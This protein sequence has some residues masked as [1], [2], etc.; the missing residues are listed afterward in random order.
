[1]LWTR[2]WLCTWVG[3]LPVKDQCVVFCNLRPLCALT[4]MQT[5][6]SLGCALDTAFAS[7]A[8]MPQ[9]TTL[10]QTPAAAGPGMAAGWVNGPPTCV[11][12]TPGP[13]LVPGFGGT[14]PPDWAAAWSRAPQ[15]FGPDGRALPG[16][17]AIPP[18]DFAGT[19]TDPNTGTTYATY[20]Q[21]MPLPIIPRGGDMDYK[22]AVRSTAGT[23][24]LALEAMTGNSALTTRPCPQEMPRD[25]AEALE[26]AKVPT[27]LLQQAVN[28][29]VAASAAR[30]TYFVNREVAKPLP[31]VHWE[32]YI[33]TT[34]V[35]RERAD[36]QTVQD[37]DGGGTALLPDRPQAPDLTLVVPMAKDP[38]GLG[39]PLAPSRRLLAHDKTTQPGRPVRDDV[40]DGRARLSTVDDRLGSARLP[41]TIRASAGRTTP[42]DS[43][44]HG[45]VPTTLLAPQNDRDS[46]R[47]AFMG[48]MAA[49]AT[50]QHL[51]P[52][53]HSAQPPQAHSDGVKGARAGL[54]G[55]LPVS[56]LA[57][58]SGS[59]SS[60]GGVAMPMA[61]QGGAGRRGDPMGG[62]PLPAR[63]S[64]QQAHQSTAGG[65][66]LTR[67]A[68][69]THFHTA[70]RDSSGP[71]LRVAPP[72]VV[73]APSLPA[74]VSEGVAGGRRTSGPSQPLPVRTPGLAGA[75]AATH[76][77]SAPPGLPAADAAGPGRRGQA[78]LQGA[79][80]VTHDL[81]A[82]QQPGGS[83][84]P[85]TAASAEGVRAT[86]EGPVGGARP[87]A[88]GSSAFASTATQSNVALQ[89][90]LPSS[91][92]AKLRQVEGPAGGA[93]AIATGA[94]A[95]GALGAMGAVGAGG[96]GS[97]LQLP[98]ASDR[99]GPR[100]SGE[101]PAGG[102]RPLGTA[103]SLNGGGENSGLQLTPA[104]DRA[105]PRTSGEG[106]AGGARPLAT[107]S[108]AAE[109]A[110]IGRP[111]FT[112]TASAL[113]AAQS[114]AFSA[115]RKV[116]RP[117][118]PAGGARP[119]ASG[120]GAMEH[121]GPSAGGGGG[122][123]AAG[124]LAAAPSP[125][126]R[127]LATWNEGPVGGARGPTLSAPGWTTNPSMAAP[128]PGPA[129]VPGSRVRALEGPAGGAR[130]ISTGATL[131]MP[132]G[133]AADTSTAATESGPRT[134]FR[135]GAVTA[136]PRGPGPAVLPR[137]VAA[138]AAS[139]RLPT[140]PMMD[141][142]TRGKN[143]LGNPAEPVRTPFLLGSETAGAPPSAFPTTPAADPATKWGSQAGM[144]H[145]LPTT[146]LPGGLP[147]ALAQTGMGMGAPT[148]FQGARAAREPQ[149]P[150]GTRVSA[151][152]AAQQVH[153]DSSLAPGASQSSRSV[154]QLGHADLPNATRVQYGVHGVPITAPS[155]PAAVPSRDGV[156]GG[157]GLG[158]RAPRVAQ[159]Q[160]HSQTQ[161]EA[162]LGPQDALGVRAARH[163]M[164]PG[165]ATRASGVHLAQS[166][167]VSGTGVGPAVAAD[168]V[169]AA[170]RYL[171]PGATT[172]AP[173][174]SLSADGGTATT[175]APPMVPI[176]DGTRA[177]RTYLGPGAATDIG[178]SRT[179]FWADSPSGYAAMKAH[180]AKDR[181]DTSN[182]TLD[183]VLQHTSLLREVL[184]SAHPATGPS[185]NATY[186][187]PCKTPVA[188]LAESAVDLRN[189][190]AQAQTALLA[191]ALLPHAHATAVPR[192]DPVTEAGY[193]SDV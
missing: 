117:E 57:V 121:Q 102:S 172:Y 46:G 91:A 151:Q 175:A 123:W 147:G 174:V 120:A 25:W 185:V 189:N 182:N 93:R 139:Q 73:S 130:P 192:I 59:G 19:M 47:D 108:S 78:A 133:A 190:A 3:V 128:A 71:A 45:P 70:A 4:K 7:T 9:G 107:G 131:L 32:G 36:T 30:D 31:D 180:P 89:P 115:S 186:V 132:A 15:G 80:P 138:A 146:V 187:T 104:S 161:A 136:N 137:D 37:Y 178:R 79:L 18:G 22:A 67:E 176:T 141:A 81:N 184:L 114:G 53:G 95:M 153:G 62:A 74:A 97:G 183:K 124:L 188:V 191:A 23:A 68:P 63:A 143:P 94:S 16:G 28:A 106:P 58:A 56:G 193:E 54:A 24:A 55:A 159:A 86:A 52:H 118:G 14:A 142:V 140:A 11:D 167:T 157:A 8:G 72:T 2:V 164:G 127:A 5:Q 12:L 96:E 110:G 61:T 87:L 85:S 39:G 1:M 156:R 105:G 69:A 165:D 150:A 155:P 38:T 35:L 109:A 112:G 154:G 100:T 160:V 135:T 168:G 101:G 64:L 162:G 50:M 34:Y 84:L 41:H 83:N 42:A 26:G 29:S 99:A 88:S 126:D 181:G 43:Q 10:P 171:G 169:R 148:S 113:P 51:Q 111:G 149:G 116:L 166:A 145:A 158:G 134:A 60:V 82:R 65:T 44:G 144:A 122:S 152:S 49:K 129:A 90:A 6:R 77:S 40:E 21:A 27:P 170:A 20:T 125:S 76:V 17:G 98:P 33:G 92:A 13:S 66:A 173:V 103:A 75:G 48:A 177:A 163:Y 179:L 119:L